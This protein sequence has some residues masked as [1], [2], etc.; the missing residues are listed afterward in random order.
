MTTGGALLRELGHSPQRARSPRCCPRPRR[1]T[2]ARRACARPCK[3]LSQSENTLNGAHGRSAVQPIGAQP[4]A[5]ALLEL[6]VQREL[7]RLTARAPPDAR[8]SA[9]AL[10]D[11]L[12]SDACGDVVGVG[13]AHPVEYRVQPQVRLGENDVLVGLSDVAAVSFPPAQS[14]FTAIGGILAQVR[15]VREATQAIHALDT[16]PQ[17]ASCLLFVPKL[18]QE[19]HRVAAQ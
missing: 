11:L 10:C 16:P 18:R 4:Q 13:S 12:A 1:A 8:Y 3:C 6:G 5:I 14:L 9:H 17:S 19:E 15:L 2:P 7:E